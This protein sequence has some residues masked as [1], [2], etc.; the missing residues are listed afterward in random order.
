MIQ[1]CYLRH[2][3]FWCLLQCCNLVIQ[4]CY[5]R[6]CVLYQHCVTV[7]IPYYCINTVSPYQYRVTVSTLYYRINTVSPYQH[8]VTVSITI[9]LLR[10]ILYQCLVTVQHPVTVLTVVTITVS[11]LRLI[12]YQRLVTVQHPVTV[13]TV[14]TITVSLLRLIPYQRLLTVQH[15][16]TV[17]I[18]VTITVSTVV[19]LQRLQYQLVVTQ[20]VS[21]F[22]NKTVS[23]S[24]PW[25]GYWLCVG[26][27]MYLK[28]MQSKMKCV[29]NEIIFKIYWN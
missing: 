22:C 26:T 28:L 15:P 25:Y 7:S 6:H 16:V 14:V 10:L 5:L 23:I 13:S 21:I 29:E 3:V 11:L 1:N 20:T 8:R 24:T 19:T 4:N 9:S 18:V 27:P 12:L 17:S 2:C